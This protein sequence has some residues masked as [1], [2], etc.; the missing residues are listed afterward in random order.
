MILVTGAAGKTGRAI[1][2]ALADRSEPV[3][4]LVRRQDQ[5]RLVTAL[6][7]QQVFVG[8]MRLPATLSQAATGAR[9]VYLICPNVSPDELLM[10]ENALTA[11]RAAGLER[12]VYHSVLHPQTES[13]P[14]H[15][16]KLRVEE[17]LFQ[18]GLVFTI[19]QPTVYMQ[20]LLAHWT[21]IV[22][23]GVYPIPYHAD[24]RLSLVDLEDVASAAAQILTDRGHQ[25]ATYE[26]VGTGPLTPTD[27]AA[28]LSAALSRPV[29]VR[30]IHLAEWESN[31]RASGLGDYEV[32]CLLRMFRYYERFG[33]WG[34]TR[35]LEGLLG[36]PPASLTDFARKVGH[37][38][39]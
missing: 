29:Q 32:D 19:L 21:Q 30:S 25:G 16:A 22:Q 20:N 13:M 39:K 31:A 7:A 37:T 4:A 9:A 15:W 23:Q 28:A 26:L 6:G 8:D 11:A 14:H 18:S 3:R 33:L 10:A 2:R 35:V 5:A 17:L 1:I 36:H 24:T 27:I 38:G 34:N 12:F